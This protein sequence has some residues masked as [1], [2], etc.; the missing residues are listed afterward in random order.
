MNPSGPAASTSRSKSSPLMSTATPPPSGP[1]TFSTG[2]SQSS[3]TSS[4]V[5]EPR[6]PI[7]SSA[8]ET[9]KPGVPFSTKNARDAAR[10]A[11]GARVDDERVRV[12]R[13]GDPKLR[14]V[15]HEAIAA[16]LRA[17]LHRHH[18]GTRSGLAHRERSHML[19]AEELRQVARLL[20][21]VRPAPDLVDAKIGMGAIGEPYRSGR[22]RNLLHRDDV[23]E[24]AQP[25]AAPLLLDR[26]SVQSEFAHE[27]PQ[28]TR[29]DIGRVDAGGDRLD[30]LSSES[31]GR[32][33]DRVGGRT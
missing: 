25:Q 21:R 33:A 19:A 20:F 12:R 11:W 4:A 2:I 5:S 22:A 10:V 24:V 18:V 8:L 28:L 17:Q 29:E 16:A 31:R 30:L 14:A 6:M 1:R 23:F 13:V 32:F 26:D 9:R 15:E 7:F 27:R 3:N